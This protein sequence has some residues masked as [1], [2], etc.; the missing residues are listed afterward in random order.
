MTDLLGADDFQPSDDPTIAAAEA[1]EKKTKKEISSAL[2]RL[3]EALPL[4]ALIGA[5]RRQDWTGVSNVIPF[6]R[7]DHDLTNALDGLTDAFTN[8]GK[9]AASGV[10]VPETLESPLSFNRIHAKSLAA[11]QQQRLA[12]VEGIEDGVRQSIVTAIRTGLSTGQTPEQ[13]GEAIQNMIGL[14]PKQA[15]AVANYRQLLEQGNTAALRRA[16]RDQ[17]FDASVARLLRDGQQIDAA[18]IDRMVER[19]ADRMRSYRAQA[20]ARTE[21]LRAAVAGQRAAYEQAIERFGWDR[22]GVRRFWQIA[23]DERTCP[24]CR[25]VPALN[26]KGVAMDEP[27]QSSAGPIDAPPQHPNCRCTEAYEVANVVQ[28]DWS[29]QQ[30]RGRPRGGSG[31]GRNMP[32]Y[33]TIAL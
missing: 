18:K 2:T 32:D 22:G 4:V 8:A 6:K 28:P 19:Y 9:A 24:V 31:S 33:G 25:S 7:L 5:I 27:Y 1:A 30:V 29:R 26:P 11:L 21:T 12:L 23:A 3:S 10:P 14:S 16:L 20:I 15:Q 13:I 17:R